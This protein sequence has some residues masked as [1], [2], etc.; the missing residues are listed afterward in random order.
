ME[1]TYGNTKLKKMLEDEKVLIR[2]YGQRIAN[3]INQRI[4]ELLAAENPQCLPPA[5]RF[6][7]HNGERKGLFSLDLVYPKRLIVRPTCEYEDYTKITSVEI[8][9]IMDPH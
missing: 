3:L 6:H 1:I 9:E 8:Y 4:S 7:E 5:C 2:H